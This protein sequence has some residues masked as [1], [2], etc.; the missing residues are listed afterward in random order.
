MSTKRLT[1]S[2]LFL[3][4]LLPLAYAQAWVGLTLDLGK[5]YTGEVVNDISLL[6]FDATDSVYYPYTFDTILN[7]D[8]GYTPLS[9]GCFHFGGMI[10]G[11]ASFSYTSLINETP[12]PIVNNGDATTIWFAVSP[13]VAGRFLLSPNNYLT[14]GAGITYFVYGN[15]NE[16]WSLI[17]IPGGDE[18][19]W[20][21]GS[22]G[23]GPAV[24]IQF[25]FNS[26]V[27]EAGL[28][29]PDFYIGTGVTF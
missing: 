12:G 18:E 22:T 25:S 16:T 19:A 20:I 21:G 28:T 27:L 26:I 24:L 6:A 7:L 1:L 11:S 2:I 14:I 17:N 5:P 8:L 3:S 4:V 29:G 9:I 23:F 10:R 13:M 15:L